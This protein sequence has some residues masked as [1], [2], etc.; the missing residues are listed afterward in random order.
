M[1][2]PVAA[3]YVIKSGSFVSRI[4]KGI[5][6]IMLQENELT[7]M[8]FL[9]GIFAGTPIMGV[10]ALLAVVTGTLAAII[11]KFNS[12]NINKGLYGF[13]AALTGA[14]L[15]LFFKPTIMIWLLVVIGAVLAACLQHIFISR[16]I[17]VFT[18]PFVLVTWLLIYFVK[19]VFPETAVIF[20]VST[21]ELHYLAFPVKG[22]G[23][24]IFQDNLTSGLLFIAGVALCSPLAASYGFAGAFLSGIL[25][26]I[27]F[28]VHGST[29]A[30][31]L[32][33]F[34]AVLCA[35]ALAGRKPVNLLSALAAVIL[36]LFISIQMVQYGFIQLTF[37]F[38]AATMIVISLQK[39]R[40]TEK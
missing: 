13:S 5:S 36:S 3:K 25:A 37:P 2:M 19:K 35:I 38:V 40:V 12:D 14:A 29:I 31:G 21:S 32:F 23:Q 17:S 18:L 28:M 4:L 11:L 27:F 10:A 7:G 1:N 26:H 9:A 6:Q 22:F 33:S 8:L 15:V 20:P 16:N 30:D 24:V 39:I 34:N